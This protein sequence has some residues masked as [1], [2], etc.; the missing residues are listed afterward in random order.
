M[1]PPDA[2]RQDIQGLRAIAVVSVL[3]F[4]AFPGLLSGGFAGV[5]IF[6]VISGFLISSILYRDIQ[7]GEFA[8]LDFYRNRVRRLFPALIPVLIA[9]LA[10][11]YLVLS[12]LRF[13]ELAR[14]T[15]YSALFLANLDFYLMSGY[16]SQASELK[17]LLHTWSLAVEEQFYL[18]WWYAMPRAP[19][20]HW[21]P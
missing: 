11:G 20:W 8:L 2:Y 7:S 4:H 5:D 1:S 18:G 12:P 17:P 13:D 19:C 3:V 6:F 14:S 9:T 16:F 21:L 10:L 15:M